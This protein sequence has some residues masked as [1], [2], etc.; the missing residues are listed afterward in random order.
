MPTSVSTGI[1]ALR[2]ASPKKIWRG[3]K[4]NARDVRT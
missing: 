3:L 4:P 2:S 1:S